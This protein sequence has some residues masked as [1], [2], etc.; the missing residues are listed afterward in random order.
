MMID[1]GG[2]DDV[3]EMRDLRAALSYRGAQFQT[4]LGKGANWEL[5]KESSIC[6]YCGVGCKIDFYTNKQGL[7]VKT[8]GHD[9]GPNKGHLCVKG[10]F[11][12]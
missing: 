10:P 12:F 5:K 8:M 3:Y 11:R 6:I 1:F 9:D 4:V 7:L 2:I